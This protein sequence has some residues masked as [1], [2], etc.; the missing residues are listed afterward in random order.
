MHKLIVKLA[1]IQAKV[2]GMN[3]FKPCKHVKQHMWTHEIFVD[4]LMPWWA[5]FSV[6]HLDFYWCLDGGEW[7]YNLV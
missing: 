4:A 7:G 1:T 2:R 5:C 6:N 3:H